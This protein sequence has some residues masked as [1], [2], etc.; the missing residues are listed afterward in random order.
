M[1]LIDQHED[2]AAD[3]KRQLRLNAIPSRS[4][5]VAAPLLASRRNQTENTTETSG[6]PFRTPR[7][8]GHTRCQISNAATRQPT[9]AA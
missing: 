6:A 3:E 8:P 5:P 1:L 7:I 9:C 2:R 4:G